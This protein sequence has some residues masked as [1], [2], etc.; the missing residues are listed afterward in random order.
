MDSIQIKA[1][2]KINWLLNITG[3]TD[4]GYHLLD[5]LMQ[6]IE[7]CDDLCFRKTDETRLYINGE[8]DC[9]LHENLIYKAI[10]A[11]EKYTGR[12]LSAEVEITKRIP[13]RA[14]LGGGSS[15][16]AAALSAINYLYD[17]RLEK[18]ELERI[19]LS[20]GADVPFFFTQGLCEVQGIGECVRRIEGGKNWPLLIRLVGEGLSTPDIYRRYD[21]SETQRKGDSSAAG[22][23]LLKMER[24]SELSLKTRNDLEDPAC[25]AEPGIKTAEKLF[26]DHGALF[27]R[28]SGSGSAVFAVF[29]TKSEAQRC[30]LLIPN[31]I[32][33]YTLAGNMPIMT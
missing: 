27:S 30:R 2:A 9:R 17:L 23:E 33:T 14:G 22:A 1:N 21:L 25:E 20:L 18:N 4:N 32:I 13:S 19:G 29:S 15:D 10:L 26:M 6:S 3:R 24:F 11:L 8:C 28:M 7:L 31:S 12:K 16:C 5:M